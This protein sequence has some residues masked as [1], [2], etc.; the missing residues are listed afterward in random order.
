MKQKIFSF[1][2]MCSLML[3]VTSCF[4][5]DSTAWNNPLTRIT[6]DGIES[7][8]EKTAY[9]GDRLQIQPIVETGLSDDKVQYQWTLLC[10]KTGDVTASGDTLQPIEIGTAKDLDYEVNVAPGKYQ[11]RLSVTDKVTGN[12]ALAMDSLFKGESNTNIQ[13]FWN[14]LYQ[15]D[16]ER[17]LFQNRFHLD[18]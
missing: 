11:I 4:D 10:E 7:A 16:K 1:A 17:Y 18:N 6:I 14:T 8:Y 15:K 13:N 2:F 5:D 12:A 3:L 9:V